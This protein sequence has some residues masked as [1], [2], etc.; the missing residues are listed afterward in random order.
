MK[1]KVKRE[2]KKP[3]QK[4]NQSLHFWSI[5]ESVL[6]FVSFTDC[7]IVQ[8]RII[9][10]VKKSKTEVTSSILLKIDIDAWP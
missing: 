8:I 6:T 7:L 3:K 4:T 2:R 9:E 5:L 1:P 10:T